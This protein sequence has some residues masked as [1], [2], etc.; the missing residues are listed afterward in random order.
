MTFGKDSV[1]PVK[2][3]D[4]LPTVVCRRGRPLGASRLLEMVESMVIEGGL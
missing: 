3:G 1:L 2:E 4:E